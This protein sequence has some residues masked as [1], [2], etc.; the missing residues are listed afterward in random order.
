MQAQGGRLS[1]TGSGR[2]GCGRGRGRGRGLG[3]QAGPR[4]FL[5]GFFFGFDSD[6]Q[7]EGKGLAALG[8]WELA[9]IA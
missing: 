2:A 6:T 7:C 3:P 9:G 8:V 5:G 4:I 1:G